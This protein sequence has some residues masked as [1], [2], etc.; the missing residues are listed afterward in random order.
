LF[1][2]AS[3]HKSTVVELNIRIIETYNTQ[4]V[5]QYEHVFFMFVLIISHNYYM[6]YDCKNVLYLMY[7]VIL[8]SIFR[9]EKSPYEVVIL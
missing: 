8:K 5:E 6:S 4:Q 9:P 3:N 1:S 7:Y 2:Y